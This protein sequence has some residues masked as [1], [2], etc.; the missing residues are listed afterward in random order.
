M[1]PL[2]PDRTLALSYV[3]ASRRAAAT[4]PVQVLRYE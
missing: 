1:T 2:D 3:S 4:D